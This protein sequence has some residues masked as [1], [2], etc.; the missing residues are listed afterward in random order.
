MTTSIL[1]A[2]RQ[3]HEAPERGSMTGFGTL[4]R[5][6]LGFWW[7]TRRWWVHTLLWLGLMNGFMVPVYF[8]VQAHPEAG[9]DLL[10]QL[11]KL[12]FTLGGT[13]VAIG[14]IVVGQD[15]IISERQLG[16]AAWILS[17]PVARTAFLL[18]K[19]VAQVVSF[20]V[21]AVGIQAAV[22]YGQIALLEGTLLAPIPYL[23]A[24]GL[25][26]VNLL[27]YIALVLML[28]TL[29]R[30]RSQVLLVALGW[31]FASPLLVVDMVPWLTNVVPFGLP[32]I[33]A[34]LTMGMPLA[35]VPLRPVALALI[36]TV[37]FLAVAIR[38]FGHEEL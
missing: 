18:A 26:C 24:V 31:L 25:I 23:M 16:T 17:K 33:G 8:V 20:T 5:K 30:T 7:S 35:D 6:E 13:T 37:A 4:L 12:F 36:W 22:A 21:L 15:A 10:D 2:G 28:G 32:D 3:L 27:F 11:T 14:A 29:F 34:A 1:S 9:L 19:F 38:R